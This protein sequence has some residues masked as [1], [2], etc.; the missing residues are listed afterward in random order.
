MAELMGMLTKDRQAAGVPETYHLISDDEVQA[1]KALNIPYTKY[2]CPTS[3]IVRD[4][5]GWASEDVY[6][7]IIAYEEQDGYADLTLQDWLAK[8]G[9]S[10]K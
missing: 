4:N 3:L 8:L 5:L 7:L 6:D 1:L 10:D 2:I 9:S